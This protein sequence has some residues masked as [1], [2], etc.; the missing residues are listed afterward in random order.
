MITKRI[1]QPPTLE[2]QAA[3]IPLLPKHTAYNTLFSERREAHLMSCMMQ[4]IYYKDCVLISYEN[5]QN[6]NNMP[7]LG[8]FQGDSDLQGNRYSLCISSALPMTT[9][10]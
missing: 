5:E 9:E 1:P 3:S 8:F 7:F 10:V 2:I 6:I 4:A